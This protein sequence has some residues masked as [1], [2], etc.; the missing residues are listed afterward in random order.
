MN[1]CTRGATLDMFIIKLPVHPIGTVK[2]DLPLSTLEAQ[3]SV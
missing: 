2:S 1:T 3:L